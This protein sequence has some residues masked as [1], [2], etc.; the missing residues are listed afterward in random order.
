M[1]ISQ[2]D[3]ISGGFWGALVGDALGV[4]VEFTARDERK[5]D[6]VVGM[7]AFGTHHQPAGTWSD[8]SSLLLCTMES[9]C[10]GFDPVDIGSRFIRWLDEGYWTPY[11]EVFDCGIATQQAIARLRRGVDP[12]SAGGAGER[13]NGNGSLMRILPVACY[14]ADAPTATLLDAAHR[15]SA[16]THRHPRSQMACGMACLVAQALMQGQCIEGAYRS[17][18][19]EAATVYTALPFAAERTHFV[20]VLDGQLADVPESD[21]SGDGYVVHTLEASLWCLLTTSSFEE[22]VLKAVNLGDDAD[23][24]GCVTGGLAGLAYGVDAIP[25][26]WREC[27]ARA[28]DIAAS[29][30]RFTEACASPVTVDRQSK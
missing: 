9:L 24:T 21:I 2:H 22:A 14:F 20:R 11:G 23:T 18:I 27:L 19:T 16:V 6:P 29:L 7:R 3:R 25:L 8:D 30:Q 5:R 17:A 26:P 15:V 4:P 13:D 12:E 28:G 1:M 10:A